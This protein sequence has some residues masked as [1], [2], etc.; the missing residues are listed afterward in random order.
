MGITP[1][2]RSGRRRKNVERKIEMVVSPEGKLFTSDAS[3]RP[4]C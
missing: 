3:G 2:K 4:P 1:S